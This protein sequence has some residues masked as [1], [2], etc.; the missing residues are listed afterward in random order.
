MNEEE[1]YQWA[2]DQTADSPYVGRTAADLVRDLEGLEERGPDGTSPDDI[3]SL[4]DE[5]I[6][7]RCRYPELT[8]FESRFGVT[9]WRWSSD[10]SSSEAWQ[11]VL[12]GARALASQ[13]REVANDDTPYPLEALRAALGPNPPG[14]GYPWIHPRDEDS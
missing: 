6:A 1:W 3:S 8:R 5:C 7:W 14:T 13:L 10:R 2:A 11:E 12:N 9:G 4:A